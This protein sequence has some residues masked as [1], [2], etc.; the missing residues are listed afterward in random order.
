MKYYLC[1]I[2]NL[3]CIF[4]AYSALQQPNWQRKVV[5]YERNLYK[6]GFQNWMLAQSGDNWMYFANSNGLLE[7]DGTN[8]MLYSVRN[9]VIRSVKV[10]DNKIYIGGSTEFGFFETDDIGRLIYHSLSEKTEH[11]GG[12]VW[13]ILDND[14]H[15]YFV[16]EHSIHRYNKNGG[17]I[18]TIDSSSKI[19]CSAWFNNALYIGTVDGIFS[20]SNNNQFVLLPQSKP[21]AGNKFVNLC[22]YKDKL[23]ITTS[24]SGLFLLDNLN[25][26]TRVQSIADDFIRDNQLFSSTVSETKIALGSVQNGVFIFDMESPSYKESFDIQNGLKNNTVLNCFFD[27]DQNLWLGLDKGIAYIDLKSPIRPLFATLSPIG[28]GYCSMVYNNR[29]YLGTNQA[30]YEVGEDGN[31]KLVNRSEGQIW[32]LNIVG[33]TLFSSGDNGVIVISPSE[34]YK[35]NIPGAWET[36]VLSADKG[37]LIVGTYSGFY[38]IEKKGN[39]WQLSHKVPGFMDSCRG[40]IE[41]DES[42]SFWVANTNSDIQKVT[43]NKEFNK[44][45][46]K[47]EYLLKNSTIAANTV[48]R[49][50]DNNLVICTNDG[51]YQYS[52]ISDSFDRYHQLESRLEGSKYYDYLF[53]DKYKNLWFVSDQQLKFIPY[54]RGEYKRKYNWKLADELINSYENVYLPDSS[55]AIVSVNN[56]FFK[57]DLSQKQKIENDVKSF[58]R[59]VVCSKNDSIICY[60]KSTKPIELPYHLNSVKI[61]FAAT[62]YMHT[63]DILYTYKLSGVD[64]EWSATSSNTIKEYTNLQAGSYIFELKAFINGDA[65]PDKATILSFRINPPWYKSSIAYSIYFICLF[66]LLYI[67]YKKTICKQKKIIYQKGEELIAQSKRH[68]EET[69]SKNREIYEL[70]NENLRN[71]L[72]YKTQEVNGHL[73]NIVRKNELLVNIKKS[74]L[75]ISKAIDDGKQENIIRQKVM[76]LI[77][78]INSSLEHDNDFDVFQSNFDTI[79]QNFFKI[80]DEKYPQLSRNDKILCAYLKMNLSSKEIAPLLNISIRGV[81]VNRYRLRKKMNLDRDVNLSEYMN[82]LK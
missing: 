57:I 71:R 5:N 2:Y 30:L 37:K 6:G 81:E 3:L 62:N 68:E 55:T 75:T 28:T 15:F 80:L 25:S 43:F 33:E 45:I 39:H 27:K 41:D 60:G 10:I 49:V 70:Q 76:G 35:I 31:C 32:S 26:I 82:N 34:T 50:I 29:I 56:S 24:K 19:D 73:L 74:A 13:N 46:K 36:H 48:F 72:R 58:V 77:S 20:L 7:F 8:W 12:E 52:R 44:I 65:I 69:E 47:K 38:I 18:I 78:Q 21:L 40:F 59:T 1:L 22:A 54:D 23:L 66:I 63:S 42:Y 53:S 9:N 4:N 17:G 61:Y 11:W 51:I 64:N 67:L 79:H 14:E 16:S